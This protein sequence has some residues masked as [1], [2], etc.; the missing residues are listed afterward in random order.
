MGTGVATRDEGNPRRWGYVGYVSVTVLVVAGVAH[1]FAMNGVYPDMSQNP[2]IL[3]IID[4]VY[5]AGSLF[6]HAYWSQYWS[7]IVVVPLVIVFTWAT[8]NRHVL[9]VIVIT[10][11]LK[12]FS[13]I[14][15]VAE[16]GF[17]VSGVVYAVFGAVLFHGVHI[18]S[19]MRRRKTT[20]TRSTV[21]KGRSHVGSVHFGY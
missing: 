10:A 15:T 19:K 13:T 17:G 18:A 14:L 4:P 16:G 5:Y 3:I 21:P 7:N 9:A 20:T 12:T 2:S 8:S 6:L 1:W 11:F